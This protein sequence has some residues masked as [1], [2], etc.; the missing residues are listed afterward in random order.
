MTCV[1]AAL[2]AASTTFGEG[3]ASE[4]PAGPAP[5][6]ALVSGAAPK[7]PPAPSPAAVSPDVDAPSR[8]NSK[9][10]LGSSPPHLAPS[11][12][13]AD[14]TTEPTSHRLAPTHAVASVGLHEGNVGPCPSSGVVDADFKK[15][16]KF[17]I[18][19]ASKSEVEDR[20]ALSEVMFDEEYM[21]RG[22]M[23]SSSVRRKGCEHDVSHV[24]HGKE[25]ERKVE[26]EKLFT[27]RVPSYSAHAPRALHTKIFAPSP[28]RATR[29][30]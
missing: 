2:V 26:K 19:K 14:A 10:L 15:L 11:E 9:T 3:A 18:P 24:E 12:A 20:G 25:E 28:L 1:H 27:K 30:L 7:P 17:R 22:W 23:S 16:K 29:E 4:P 21:R 13:E 6:K 8:A 5:S